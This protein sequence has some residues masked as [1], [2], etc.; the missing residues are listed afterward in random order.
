[1]TDFAI[2]PEALQATLVQTLGDKARSVTVALG[3]VT[4]VVSAATTST[5]HCCCAMR[6]AAA[7]SS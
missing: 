1:M 6:R 2:S 7:S 5:R 4:V 3:E